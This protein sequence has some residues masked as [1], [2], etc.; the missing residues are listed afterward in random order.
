M[1]SREYIH[2]KASVMG[3]ALDEL[4]PTFA[5]A[6]VA[7]VDLPS[8]SEVARVLILLDDV[9]YPGYR[10]DWD[11]GQPIETLLIERL[12]EAYDALYRQIKRA[13][14][15]R[16]Q[17]KYAADVPGSPEAGLEA[18]ARRVLGAFF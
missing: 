14:P 3:R 2:H 16:S 11:R 1:S 5:S 17:S 4:V 12:G 15:L 6:S 18:E 7:C 8:E 13:L 10:S 9:F